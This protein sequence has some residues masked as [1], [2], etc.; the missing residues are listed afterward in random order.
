MTACLSVGL[1][2]LTLNSRKMLQFITDEKASKPIP[3]QVKEFIDGG[4]QWIELSAPSLD[5]GEMEAVAREIIPACRE[6]NAFVIMRQHTELAGELR[7]GGVFL[8][9]C[10]DA[11][12]VREQ[13][14]GEAII[15]VAVSGLSDILSLKG[16]DVDYAVMTVSSQLDM[17]EKVAIVA[18]A[19]SAGIAMPIVAQGEFSVDEA[20][21]LVDKGFSGIAL[22]SVLA[23]ADD[24]A[25]ETR[26][27][28]EALL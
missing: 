22:S 8:S 28:L 20:R 11:R 19:R 26:R 17:D 13:L 21:R 10:T 6:A 14:G 15:G 2:A 16:I 9:D 4:G 1:P 23:G 25:K 3:R 27:Y 5:R 24:T 12:R 18:E 7:L